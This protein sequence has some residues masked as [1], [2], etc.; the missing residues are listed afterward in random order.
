LVP[1]GLSTVFPSL[2]LSPLI[3]PTFSLANEF[4]LYLMTPVVLL[5]SSVTL[6]ALCL[7][8]GLFCLSSFG[9]ISFPDT[10]FLFIPGPLI[11]FLLG[12]FICKSQWR[13]L[14]GTLL[15]LIL[16]H[17]YLAYA[18][19]WS[20]GYNKEIY[21]SLYSG[22]FLLLVLRNIKPHSFDNWL[23]AISYGCFLAHVLLQVIFSRYWWGN[24]TLIYNIVLIVVSVGC[25]TLSYL[26]IERPTINYRRQLRDKNSLKDSIENKTEHNT[27]FAAAHP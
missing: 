8:L 4:L 21:L 20:S 13:Y 9:A 7:C 19:L 27:G 26:F 11:F 25:G 2:H 5:F 24:N 22:V 15:V 16:N 3:P 23:G 6:P 10:Y 18:G 17:S 14:A 1:L 12:H